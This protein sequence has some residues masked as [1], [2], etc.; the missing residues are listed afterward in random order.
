MRV[1]WGNADIFVEVFNLVTLSPGYPIAGSSRICSAFKALVVLCGTILH[2][3]HLVGNLL[4]DNKFCAVTKAF[5]KLFKK[6]HSKS[7]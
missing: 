6:G 5:H 3:H 1:V 7:V 2:L 4:C